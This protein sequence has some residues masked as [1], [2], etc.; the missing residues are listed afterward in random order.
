MLRK[1]TVLL[2]VLLLAAGS[3]SAKTYE[4]ESIDRI[5]DGDT[6]EMTVDLGFGLSFFIKTRLYG[7]D[8]W[9]VTGD[10]KPKGILAEKFLKEALDGAE[11]ITV[12]V[13]EKE[14]GKYGRVL[15]TIY[16]DEVN[17]NK[18]LVKHGHAEE[19]YY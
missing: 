17:L 12:E 11:N 2:S 6:V 3:L 16:V 10:E 4:V 1:L 15:V 19:N 13:P 8:A 9:E 5:I 14:R 7:I 18:L